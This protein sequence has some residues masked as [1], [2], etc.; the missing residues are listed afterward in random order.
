MKPTHTVLR[1][2]PGPNGDLKPGTEVD[3]SEW[4]NAVLLERQRFIK[5]LDGVEASVDLTSNEMIDLRGQVTEIVLA[6][7]REDGP[8]A[9]ALRMVT[10]ASSG[11][12]R[13]R[14]KLAETT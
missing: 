6:D 9:H 5:R 4:R 10:A 2:F 1:K 14:E 11:K 12:T 3:A 7:L 8:I 13:K